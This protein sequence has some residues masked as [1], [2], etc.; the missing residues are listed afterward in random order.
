MSV[1][2]LSRAVARA[3][4]ADVVAAEVQAREH[5]VV[6]DGRR[7][8][9]RDLSADP[10]VGELRLVSVASLLKAAESDRAP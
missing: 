5:R 10:Y 3:F 6:V 4:S 9:P 1:A 7:E 2:L 8:R